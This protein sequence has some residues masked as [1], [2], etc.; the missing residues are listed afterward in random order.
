M[1]PF[2]SEATEEKRRCAWCRK[3][4][5]TDESTNLSGTM[6]SS[7]ASDARTEYAAQGEPF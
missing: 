5:L 2:G 6:H 7:C 4:I 3:A 1:I